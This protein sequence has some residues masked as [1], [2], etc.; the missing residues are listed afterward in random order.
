MYEGGTEG[1][2]TPMSPLLT[3]PPGPLDDK[4]TDLPSA[5]MA[6]VLPR[7]RKPRISPFPDER[8]PLLP[9]H[10]VDQTLLSPTDHPTAGPYRL[11]DLSRW[12]LRTSPTAANP[13]T[14]QNRHTLYAATTTGCR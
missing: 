10:L 9:A 1:S 6:K 7:P 5:T 11:P 2:P 14:E 8:V 4:E 3:P 13:R 12:I